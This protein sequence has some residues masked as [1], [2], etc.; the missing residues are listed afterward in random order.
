MYQYTLAQKVMIPFLKRAGVDLAGKSVLDVGCGQGGL[1][2]FVSNSYAIESGLGI[3]VDRQVIQRA[4]RARAA[5]VQFQ[6]MDFLSMADDRVYDFV[7]LRD[8]LEHIV[9]VERAFFKASVLVRDGGYL[10]I[11]YSPFYSPFGGHQHNGT[12]PFSFFPWLQIL[13]DWLFLPMIGLRGNVYKTRKNLEADVKSVLRTRI[14]VKQVVSLIKKSKMKM[15]YR[16]RSFVRPDYQV[17]FGIKAV[18]LPQSYL[19]ILTEL[20]CTGEEL[21]LQKA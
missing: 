7:M 10:Y 18:P 6:V 3:D 17:K 11:T 1:L 13:P 16:C 20:L 9:H 15:L 5:R 19:P 2:H 21:L 4:K 14:T 8:V 12:G